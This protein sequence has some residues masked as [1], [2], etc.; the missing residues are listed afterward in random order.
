MNSKYNRCG[1]LLNSD[2]I[3]YQGCDIPCL[4]VLQG[5]CLTSV[6]VK[7]IEQLCVVTGL[8]DLSTLIIPDCL[9]MAFGT[10]DVNILN[11][12]QILLNQVCDNTTNISTINGQLDS[13][14]PLV[15]VDFACCSTNPCVTNGT[16][17][18]SVALENLISCLCIQN[19]KI[20]DLENQ[21]LGYQT[22]I[23][24]LISQYNNLNSSVTS[25]A[26]QFNTL[27]TSNTDLINS[28]N[29][30]KTTITAA[31]SF[32]INISVC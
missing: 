18:L 27:A 20:T 2:C 1:E 6:Q 9:K 7:I 25:L 28:V 31:S 13:L 12:I 3:I 8:T 5:D 14:N 4:G 26:T 24:S 11:S 15:T 23:N 16:V 29:C 19:S 10:K 17:R 30:I 22:Q 21:L 32:P